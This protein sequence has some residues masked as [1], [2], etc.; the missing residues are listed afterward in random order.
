MD[1][2]AGQIDLNHASPAEL[3]TLPDVSKSIA[4]RIVVARPHDRVRDL[5]VVPGV[6]PDKL[7]R[8]EATGKA[9]STPLTLPPPASDVCTKDGQLDVNDPA[10]RAGIADLFGAPTA[11]R[12]VD[13]Q[14]FADLAHAKVVLAAGAGPGKVEKYAPRLCLTPEPKI[15]RNVNYSWAYARPG[16]RADYSGFSLVVPAG[17]IDEPIGA[18]LRVTPQDPDL[19]RWPGSPYTTADFHIE[20]SWSGNG[21]HVY[22]TLPQPEYARRLTDAHYEPSLLHWTDAAHTEGEVVAGERVRQD[23]GSGA[24]TGAVRS[25]STID[26]LEHKANWLIEPA[27]GV[28]FGIRF[29]GPGCP[30]EPWSEVPNTNLWTLLGNEA[31]LTGA[32]LDLP[33]NEVPYSGFPIKHCVQTSRT[34][35]VVPFARGFYAELLVRNSTGTVARVSK[36][37]GNVALVDK[38]SLTDLLTDPVGYSVTHAGR[39]DALFVGPGGDAGAAVPPATS[40]TIDMHSDIVRSYVRLIAERAIGE[41]FDHFN[42]SAEPILKERAEIITQRVQCMISQLN[43]LGGSSVVNVVRDAAASLSDCLDFEDIFL[44]LGN[45]MGKLVDEG[46][47][48]QAQYRD[49]MR[50]SLD[51]GDAV[52]ELGKLLQIG[53]FV[54]GLAEPLGWEAPAAIRVEHFD[55][56]P[57]ADALGNVIG[58]GCVR[59]VGYG[60]TIDQGCQDRFL[61]S[62]NGATNVCDAS[63]LICTYGGTPP[64]DPTSGEC[65]FFAGSGGIQPAAPACVLWSPNV[66]WCGFGQCVPW[67]Q[68]ALHVIELTDGRSMFIDANGGAWHLPT[69]DAYW[70]CANRFG[71]YRNRTDYQYQG[72]F[73]PAN[74]A[75]YQ[76]MGDL[77][78]C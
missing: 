32:R 26:W 22:A 8:I 30:D 47:I 72:K 62:L 10:T 66:T 18:W 31:R 68:S 9:C 33:G 44:D 24:L 1:C 51:V 74:L 19:V 54:I 50:I 69:T 14:P 7:V 64:T 77:N 57:G 16:G 63:N 2:A 12:I 59:R 75:S 48:T 27:Y 25:L 36:Q 20:G 28:L 61:A 78:H 23:A 38:S 49:A 60:W 35:V 11:G 55:A 67:P 58:P 13:A 56:P 5:L 17:V 65:D 76:F 37:A 34:A 21:D 41:V 71:V 73:Y 6:G 4:D 42:G 43:A 53:G 52:R 46:R 45:R 40:G 70:S 3:Q 39:G 15:S 29:P